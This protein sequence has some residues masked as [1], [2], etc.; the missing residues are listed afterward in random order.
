MMDKLKRSAI[1]Y[2]SFINW[3][4]LVQGVPQG[5]VLGPLFLTFT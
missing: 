1:T 4:E 3:A 5:S 2:K